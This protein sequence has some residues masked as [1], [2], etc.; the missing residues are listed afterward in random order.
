VIYYEK[1]NL[2]KLLNK[3]QEDLYKNISIKPSKKVAKIIPL[4]PIEASVF[5]EHGIRIIKP[6]RIP[7]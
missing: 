1:N 5:F 4:K 7:P 6:K 2:I 3:L